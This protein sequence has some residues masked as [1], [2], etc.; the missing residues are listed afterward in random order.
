MQPPEF[1]KDKRLEESGEK[2]NSQGQWRGG[3][4]FDALM[5]HGKSK[6]KQKLKLKI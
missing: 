5:V 6:D 3:G 2:D 4:H 1:S